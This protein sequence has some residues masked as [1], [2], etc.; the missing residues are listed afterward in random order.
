MNPIRYT[1][2][3]PHYR[4]QKDDPDVDVEAVRERPGGPGEGA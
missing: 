3:H 4:T 2:H 1:I